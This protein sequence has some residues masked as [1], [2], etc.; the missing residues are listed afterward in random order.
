M[1]AV[2]INPADRDRLRTEL[3]RFA[4]NVTKRDDGTLVADFGGRA[5]FAVEP[6]G[7]VDAGMPLHDF[8]GPADR[9][10]FDHK[11]GSIDVEVDTGD[12]ALV[13]TFRRP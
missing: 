4:S 1:T 13:Y 3:D 9:L 11:G 2:S 10:A 12:A 7:T 5:H 6:D 8:D